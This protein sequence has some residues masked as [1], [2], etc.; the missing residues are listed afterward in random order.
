MARNQPRA[1]QSLIPAGSVY[2][3]SVD[4]GDI[5]AAIDQLHGQSLAVDPTD[6]ALGRGLLAAGLWP[7]NELTEE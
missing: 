2:Y 3:L 5:Q 6:R 1:V 4:D 7:A